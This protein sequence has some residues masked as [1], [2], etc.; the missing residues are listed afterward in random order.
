MVSIPAVQ[1]FSGSALTI[2]FGLAG[3][4]YRF[5]GSSFYAL[6]QKVSG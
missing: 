4:D 2:S 3:T 6:C 1:V 5:D